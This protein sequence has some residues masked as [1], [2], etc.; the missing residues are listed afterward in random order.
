MEGATAPAA[1]ARWGKGRGPKLR[2]TWCAA[3][4]HSVKTNSSQNRWLR[5]CRLR[6]P[7]LE[8]KVD[9][10]ELSWQVAWCAARIGKQ[11]Q[12]VEWNRTAMG[13]KMGIVDHR[14]VRSEWNPLGGKL[15]LLVRRTK[16]IESGIKGNPATSR[17]RKPWEWRT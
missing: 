5:I 12:A 17:S 14:R 10:Q 9:S 1:T 7:F 3:P 8:S 11:A 13:I 2:L 6:K 4:S 15:A 16:G